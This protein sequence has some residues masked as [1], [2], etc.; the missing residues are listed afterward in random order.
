MAHLSVQRASKCIGDGTSTAAGH[1]REEE[2]KE[3]R[4]ASYTL[5]CSVYGCRCK[6]GTYLRSMCAQKRLVL[7]AFECM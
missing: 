6:G 4:Q 1:K 5:S 2:K 7:A 3:R